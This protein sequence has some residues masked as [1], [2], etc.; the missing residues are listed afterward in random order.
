VASVPIRFHSV[1]PVNPAQ[2]P[3]KIKIQPLF[4]PLISYCKQYILY[5]LAEKFVITSHYHE[6]PFQTTYIIKHQL[7][8]TSFLKQPNYRPSQPTTLNPFRFNTPSY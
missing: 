2:T 6:F 5:S 7:P 8:I 1:S 4:Y 3:E